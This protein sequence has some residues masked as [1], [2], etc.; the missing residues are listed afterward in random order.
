MI[1]F[2]GAYINRG[3]VDCIVGNSDNGNKDHGADPVDR[4][5]LN[6]PR[7]ADE[8]DGKA[9]R[10][11]QQEPQSRLV[12]CPLV[13]GLLAPLLDVPLDGRDEGDPGNHVS[14]TNG[15]ESQ[16]DLNGGKA[17]LLVHETKGLNEHEDEGVGETREEG[18]DEDN[19]LSEEHA[20]GADPGGDDL[21][22]REA[23]AEGDELIRTPDVGCRIRLAATLGDAVHHDGAARLGHGEEVHELDEATKDK[24]DPD[25]PPK[26]IQLEAIHKSCYR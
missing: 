14:N 13:V 11:V 9:W 15:D 23:L 8:A 18:E 7:K 1:G 24:L 17:P 5:T 20:E 26:E 25:G 4:R 10:R 6:G 16:A 3:H 2:R 19:G 21:L 12:L 22:G